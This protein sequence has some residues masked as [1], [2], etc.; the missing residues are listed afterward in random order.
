MQPCRT[1][2]SNKPQDRTLADD[3]FNRS[4]VSI[5]PRA[6]CGPRHQQQPATFSRSAW[7]STLAMSLNWIRGPLQPVSSEA[8]GSTQPF[9]VGDDRSKSLKRAK[10][11]LPP[12][13]YAADIAASRKQVVGAL[14]QGT[15]PAASGRNRRAS[16]Y[17]GRRTGCSIAICT[18]QDPANPD[19][20]NI[21]INNSTTTT[22]L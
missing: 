7:T 5:W 2:Q 8:A 12:S 17:P 14:Q 9:C 1:Q 16:P 6:C 18:A 15:Q 11:V 22:F 20:N 21:N 10:G 3:Q 13:S 4:R 19:E